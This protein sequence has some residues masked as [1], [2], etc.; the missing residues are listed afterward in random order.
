[1]RSRPYVEWAHDGSQLAIIQQTSL[2][3]YDPHTQLKTV[4][5]MQMKHL[6]K[7]YFLDNATLAITTTN[8]NLLM[9]DINT[10][11]KIPVIA[12]HSQKIVD[13]QANNQLALCA[14]DK[15]FSISNKEGI[16]F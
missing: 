13:G 16:K 2:I 1:M 14:L 5:E 4:V 15:S 8:G 10:G 9:Y 7:V 11:R 12:K 3:L 6:S